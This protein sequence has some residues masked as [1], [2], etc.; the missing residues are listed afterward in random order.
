MHHPLAVTYWTV[1]GF[2]QDYM[3]RFIEI[4]I[5]SLDGRWRGLLLEH[6]A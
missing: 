5:T 3:Q 2:K 1:H 4:I 6:G